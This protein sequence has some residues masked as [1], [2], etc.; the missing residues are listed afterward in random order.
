[1]EVPALKRILCDILGIYFDLFIYFLSLGVLRRQCD[2]REVRA[3]MYHSSRCWGRTA[4]LHRINGHGTSGRSR[5]SSLGAA[6][7]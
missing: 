4:T 2:Q 1:M 6:G 3:A 7:G 5:L